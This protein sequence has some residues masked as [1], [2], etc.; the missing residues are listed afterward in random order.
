MEEHI[1][2][3]VKTLNYKKNVKTMQTLYRNLQSIAERGHTAVL[4][5]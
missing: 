5:L 2:Q 1:W 4:I 3:L